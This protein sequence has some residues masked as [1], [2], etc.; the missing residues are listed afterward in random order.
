MSSLQNIA[1]ALDGYRKTQNETSTQ[2]KT[3]LCVQFSFLVES[4][5]AAQKKA[6]AKDNLQVDRVIL[7]HPVP[8]RLCCEP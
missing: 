6:E 3:K 8:C 5:A 1:I 2:Y 4:L 7:E